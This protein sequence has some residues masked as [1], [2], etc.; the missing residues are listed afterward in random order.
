[1]SD[2]GLRA[3]AYYW[4]RKAP[5]IQ[6]KDGRTLKQGEASLLIEPARY[7]GFDVAKYVDRVNQIHRRQIS[8]A[9]AIFSGRRQGYD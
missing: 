4:V 8:R 6:S 5:L 3:G 7:T 2:D 1:M 9:S